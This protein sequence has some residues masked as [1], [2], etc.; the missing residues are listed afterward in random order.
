MR[1]DEVIGNQRQRMSESSDGG[2]EDQCRN[3]KMAKNSVDEPQ[4]LMY[5][6]K[7]LRFQNMFLFFF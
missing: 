7:F 2:G 3:V 4:C 1:G 5:A 6:T